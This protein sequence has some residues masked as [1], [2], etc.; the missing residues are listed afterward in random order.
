MKDNIHA[1]HRDRL[2]NEFLGH[3]DATKMPEHK[4]LEMLLFY[5]IP[6]RDTNPIAHELLTRFGS[7]S[8]VFEALSSSFGILPN[9]R[10]GGLLDV[11]FGVSTLKNC[12]Q[13]PVLAGFC[14]TSALTSTF[15]SALIL[16]PFY[17]TVWAP[18]PTK[19]GYFQP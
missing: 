10:H 7:F 6:Q 8:A 5:A 9:G 14:L 12:P 17:R 18:S 16:T 4:L 3:Q 15:S 1:G 2:R 19:G 13:S 11:N